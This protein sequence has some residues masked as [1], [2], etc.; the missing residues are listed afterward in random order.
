MP[1]TSQLNRNLSQAGEI[2][3][4]VVKAAAAATMAVIFAITIAGVFFRYFLNDPLVWS[5]ELARA[6]LVWM[7]FMFAGAAFHRGEMVAVQMLTE[8]VTPRIRALIMVPAYLATIVFL[9]ILIRQGFAYA[10]QNV[11]QTMPGIDAM[12]RSL[13]GSDDGV[14]IYWMYIA[15]PLGC[16]L[17]ALHIAIAVV[18]LALE[19][20]ASQTG[21]NETGGAA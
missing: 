3:F 12:W 18:R 19:A 8:R 5:E 16:I 14:S 2:Y 7:C 10:G 4:L 20:V 6:L 21:R 9:V 1:E 11:I 15:L 17:L 13:T